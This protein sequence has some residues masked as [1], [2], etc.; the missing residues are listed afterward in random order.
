MST[1]ELFITYPTMKDKIISLIVC[2]FI[3]NS[4][5]FAKEV[6][7]EETQTT[8][9]EN[10]LDQISAKNEELNL[11][12]ILELALKNNPKVKEAWMNIDVGKYSYRSELSNTLPRID[13]QVSYFNSKNKYDADDIPT[14]KTEGI[15]PSISLSYLLFDFGGRTADIMGFKYK[16]NTIKFETN[17]FIQNFIYQVIEA[18]YGLFSSLANEKAAK[19]SEN[20]SYE[21]FKAASVR[22]DIG[23]APLTDKLQAETSYTQKRLERERAENSVKIKRAELNYLLNLSPTTELRLSIPLLDVSKNDFQENVVNL[24]EVA[25]NN[26][27]DLKAYYETK[28][29]KKSEIYSI[30]TEW[31]PSVSLNTSYGRT[32]DLRK[33]SRSDRDN[34]NIGITASM[35]FFTGGYIYNNVAKAKSQLNIINEQIDD[36]K[37]DIELDVWTAYQDFMTA[38]RTYITS[39]TLLKSATETEKTMLGR[40]KNGKSSMLDLLN[41]QSDLATARYELINSQHNWFTSRANLVRAL[42]QMNLEELEKLNN[43]ANLDKIIDT[44][45]L[46]NSDENK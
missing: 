34:Y 38:K 19:E 30:A 35:P 8:K 32:N 24:I 16:L 17:L 46:S 28:K 9:T 40:Y 2:F 12:D 11:I 39:K 44:N 36:L 20:S 18:Y 13:G 31:L 33:G 7:L 43:A 1:G 45:N 25:L 21:A 5:L 6:L 4:S 23:L 3:V 41:A 15:T 10:G 37:K 27:P 14:N 29:A 22:Y 42:G 26:R